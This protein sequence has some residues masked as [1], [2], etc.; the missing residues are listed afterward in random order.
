MLRYG[1]ELTIDVDTTSQSIG[2][3]GTLTQQQERRRHH[4]QDGQLENDFDDHA[5]TGISP[6]PGCA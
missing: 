6:A 4:R 1:D 3:E 5:P 2:I